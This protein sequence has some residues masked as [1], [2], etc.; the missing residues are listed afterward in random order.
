MVEKFSKKMKI[1]THAFV[2]LVIVLI[3]KSIMKEKTFPKEDL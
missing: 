3:G 2:N 1:S